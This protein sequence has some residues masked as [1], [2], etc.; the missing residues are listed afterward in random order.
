MD[1]PNQ[2][3]RLTDI[4]ERAREIREDP[5]LRH[6]PIDHDIRTVAAITRIMCCSQGETVKPEKE[7]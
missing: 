4:A 6:I 2:R 7:Q 1:A 5:F 3:K